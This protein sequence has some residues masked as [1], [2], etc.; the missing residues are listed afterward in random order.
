M[1]I[2]CFI[3]LSLVCKDC[4]LS[5]KIYFIVD[6]FLL[7]AKFTHLSMFGFMLYYFG[8]SRIALSFAFMCGVYVPKSKVSS[9]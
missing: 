8:Y 5:I 4:V 6:C 1:C 9:A 7:T 2:E 3:I